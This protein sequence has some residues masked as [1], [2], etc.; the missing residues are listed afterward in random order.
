MLLLDPVIIE[1]LKNG[2]VEVIE[3]IPQD[4]LLPQERLNHHLLFMLYFLGVFEAAV[5]HVNL[6]ASFASLVEIIF[7]KLPV[8]DNSVG[9]TSVLFFFED[10]N[11]SLC[12]I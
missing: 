12:D 11:E 8:F 5:G 7:Q 3:K 1:N 9:Q 6:F 10:C 4:A 2:K